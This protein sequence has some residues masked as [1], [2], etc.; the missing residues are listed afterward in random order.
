MG[1]AIQFAGSYSAACVS[2]NECFEQDSVIGDGQ[3]V[4]FD[5]AVSYKDG[6]VCRGADPMTR[7]AQRVDHRAF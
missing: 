3:S 4:P 2:S 7:Q 1:L 6:L 5:V